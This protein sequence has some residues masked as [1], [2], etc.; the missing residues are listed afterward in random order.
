MRYTK[1]PGDATVSTFMA[2]EIEETRGATGNSKRNAYEE[3][4]GIQKFRVGATER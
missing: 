3:D 4:I 1:A 2:S